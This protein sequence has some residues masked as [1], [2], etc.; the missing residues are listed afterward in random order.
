MLPPEY[1]VWA[2]MKQRCL[3]SRSSGFANYGGRGIKVC[4]RWRKFEHFYADMGPRP[5]PALT[6]ERI[7]ND[8]DYEPSNCRWATRKEQLQN[9]RPRQKA[10]PQTL[11]S[12]S[13][14]RAARGLLDWS[15]P[16]LAE[17]S[18]VSVGT[19]KTFEKGR[20]EPKRPT[21]IAWRN[22]FAQAGV[23]FTYDDEAGGEG[24]RFRKE[25]KSR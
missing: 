21:L 12:P 20:S 3:N 2:S 5:D 23:V 7:N 8:G 18:G 19:I 24:V 14:L 16:D 1:T 6:I 9:R 25:R 13:Q 15:Q 10:P 17:H 4:E 22:A 11:C